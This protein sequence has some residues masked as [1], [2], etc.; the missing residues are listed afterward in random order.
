MVAGALHAFGR[1]MPGVFDEQ[2]RHL[3]RSV[4]LLDEPVAAPAGRKRLASRANAFVLPGQVPCLGMVLE[5]A[6]FNAELL[7]KCAKAYVLASCAGLPVARIPWR[8]RWIANGRLMKDQRRAA[9]RYA[10]GQTPEL[11]I[12]Y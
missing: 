4:A 8:V 11:S 1:D 5:R 10:S 2:I 9:A 6:I 3:G 7:E 12:A